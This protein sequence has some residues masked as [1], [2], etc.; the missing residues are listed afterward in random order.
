MDPLSPNYQCVI[1][2]LMKC[3]QDAALLCRHQAIGQARGVDLA[4]NTRRHTEKERQGK[5]KE[6]LKKCG[7]AEINIFKSVEYLK[8]L[9]FFF[10][11]FLKDN[12][13]KTNRNVIYDH[14]MLD[15]ILSKMPK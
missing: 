15:Q 12:Y 2:A 10:T 4:N 3:L 13:L 1:S 11:V 5:E 8:V 7:A 9:T 6:K 14:V